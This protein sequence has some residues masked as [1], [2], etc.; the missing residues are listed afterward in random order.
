MTVTHAVRRVPT[1]CDVCGRLASSKRVPKVHQ[2]QLLNGAVLCR[3]CR[4][5]VRDVEA[6][7]DDGPEF[8]FHFADVHVAAYAHLFENNLQVA[9]QINKTYHASVGG[10]GTCVLPIRFRSTQP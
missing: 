2:V 7:L 3:R 6:R 4:N 9:R 5:A 8:W 10:R 1:L